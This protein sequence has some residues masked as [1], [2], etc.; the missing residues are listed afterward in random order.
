VVFFLMVGFFI[1][2]ALS[3]AFM[4]IETKNRSLESLVESP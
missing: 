1:L 3:M 2:A 4:A